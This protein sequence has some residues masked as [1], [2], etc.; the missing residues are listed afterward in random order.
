MKEIGKRQSG[1]EQ[2]SGTD[3]IEV[4]GRRIGRALGW[5]AAAFLVFQLIR[6]YG[7]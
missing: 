1:D 5:A 3:K 4:W 6:T 2:A 7:G